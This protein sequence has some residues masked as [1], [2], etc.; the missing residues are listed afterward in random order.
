MIDVYEF[1]AILASYEV[2]EPHYP[3]DNEYYPNITVEKLKEWGK[4]EHYGD[5]TKQPQ[6]CSRCFAEEVLFKSRWILDKLLCKQCG[7]RTSKMFKTIDGKCICEDCSYDKFI[8][9]YV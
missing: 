2:D 6:P 1:A 9:E 3:P 7:N 8:E 4:E 5:C